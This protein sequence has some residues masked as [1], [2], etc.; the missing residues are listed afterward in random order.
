MKMNQQTQAWLQ[1][2]A[3]SGLPPLNKMPV[4]D[5]R[6]TYS[7][8]VAQCGLPAEPVANT[9]DRTIPGPG[10]P[11]PVRIYTPEGAGPFPALVY[12]HG[13]GWVIG[14]LDVVDGPCTALANR[15]GA[16]V[17]SV[18]Y[19]LAPEHPFPAAVEDAYAALV[20][21]S[22]HAG[23]LDVDATR[24]AVAGDSAGGNLS[25]VVSQLAR[26]HDGPAVA[27]QVLIYPVTDFARRT[28][29]FRDNADGFFLTAD[30]MDWF[31]ER[32]LD[33]SV[34][35]TDL[36]LSPLHAPDVSG[37][38]PALVITAAFDPLRDEGEQ[39][40]TR[41]REAGGE[42]VLTRYDGQIH[43]FAANLAGAIDEGRAALDDIGAYLCGVFGRD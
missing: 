34:D 14:G 32:Y 18:D 11:I 13:G 12:Y 24:V 28:E 5:A 17:V 10:G 38:P 3:D 36:R 15:A 41:L 23:E 29:S 39:Y 2:V 31:E 43:A 40:A 4:E 37:L 16:V 27:A 22:G 33:P 30:L 9:V 7:A 1:G 21:V 25:A 8:V 42:A 35:R 26:D 19:R 20:W 6:A